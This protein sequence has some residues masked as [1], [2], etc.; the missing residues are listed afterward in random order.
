MVQKIIDKW[1]RTLKGHASSFSEDGSTVI[2]E[3][4]I[5]D[6]WFRLLKEQ[7]TGKALIIGDSQ[8]GSNSSGGPLASILSGAGYKVDNKSVYGTHTAQALGQIPSF[9]YNIVILFTGG[10]IRSR[11]K[12]AAAI[13]NKF[14]KTTTFVIAGPPPAHE[15]KDMGAVKALY[16]KFP[17]LKQVPKEQL[18]TYFTKPTKRRGKDTAKGRERRNSSFKNA[19]SKFAPNVTYVDPRDVFG[20]TW[21][22]FPSVPKSDGIHLYGEVAAKMAQS[23]AR[24][25]LGKTKAIAVAAKAATPAAIAA[26]SERDLRKAIRR[27]PRC[28]RAGYP[29]AGVHKA[30]DSPLISEI[31]KKIQYALNQQGLLGKKGEVNEIDGKFGKKTTEAVMKF[32]SSKNLSADGC[33]GEATSA[34]MNIPIRFA[35]IQT[36]IAGAAPEPSAGEEKPAQ[37]QAKKAAAAEKQSRSLG[38]AKEKLKKKGGKINIDEEAIEKFGKFSKRA[39]AVP[40]GMLPKIVQAIKDAA[41]KHNVPED[42]LM[43]FAQIESGFNPYAIFRGDYN[44]LRGA[45]AHGLFQFMPSTGREFGMKKFPDDWFD[46]VKNSDAA[47]RYLAKSIRR[48]EKLTGKSISPETEYLT[49]IYHNQGPGGAPRIYKRSKGISV[50]KSEKGDL[51]RMKGQGGRVQR[52]MAKYPNNPWKGFLEF[53]KEK[54]ESKKRKAV[55]KASQ[56]GA[57][58]ATELAER[59][60]A[61]SMTEGVKI[62]ISKKK[63]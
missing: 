62:K 54:F 14:P 48:V 59:V 6:S 41:E 19:F 44:F 47:A 42:I 16:T 17:Y 18:P 46:P 13:I 53:F 37:S 60:A 7:K 57:P 25:A 49:Y 12:A 52:R 11:P 27:S 28:I 1:F 33:V 8:G 40:E 10:H 58:P 9:D 39:G 26:I 15:I 51:G 22:T 34:A 35:D 3:Q 32:Q 63:L 43:G 5:T 21:P 29:A 55:A 23:L 45:G 38:R 30:S 50:P 56:A 24:A 4:K 61:V 31:V 36:A 2:S 20:A